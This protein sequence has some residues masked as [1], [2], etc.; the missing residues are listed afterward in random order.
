MT[1]LNGTGDKGHGTWEGLSYRQIVRWANRQVGN[2]GGWKMAN[3]FSGGQCSCTAENFWCI[4][5]CAIQKRNLWLILRSLLLF[6]FRLKFVLTKAI[7]AGKW[8][9]YCLQARLKVFL[10]LLAQFPSH[11]HPFAEV[12]CGRVGLLPNRN[13]AQIIVTIRQSLITG[14]RRE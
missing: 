7:G 2:N 5:K 11:F 9:R 3:N 12:F 14:E 4:R 1:Q 13:L 8:G 10:P 6:S